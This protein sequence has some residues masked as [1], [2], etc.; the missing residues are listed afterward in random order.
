MLV[1]ELSEE[2]RIPNGQFTV[3]LQTDVSPP[4]DP[5]AVVEVRMRRVAVARVRFVIAAAR[6]ERTRPADAAVGLVL[7]VVF[8]EKRLLRTAIDPVAD[9]AD[10]VGVAACETVT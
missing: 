10:L 2:R 4:A 7:D 8:L 3:D 6:T 5:L 1:L 9:A